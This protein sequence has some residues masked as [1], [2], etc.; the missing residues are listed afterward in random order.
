MLTDRMKQRSAIKSPDVEAQTSGSLTN[1][2][3]QLMALGGAIGAGC[4][5]GSGAA[6]RQAGPALLIAYLLAG[7]M[8]YLI[9]RALGGL[10]LAYPSPGSFA[11]YTARFI[12]PVAGFI[13][14]WSYWFALLLVGIAEITGIGL[15]L[16]RYYPSVPQWAFA[17]CATVTL[18]V[19]N[20]RTVK[21]FGESE[22][23]LSMIK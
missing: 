22:Y 13:T 8:I 10:T 12:G 3:L 7:C 19:I 23:W 20:M 9:M 6:I 18:Y 14:G 17:L 15:L 5:L 11:A 4:F 16:H 1:R 21:S 2:H